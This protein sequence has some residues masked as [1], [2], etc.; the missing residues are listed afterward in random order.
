MLRGG[1]RRGV[2][3]KRRGG[4]EGKKEKRAEKSGGGERRWAENRQEGNERDG[5]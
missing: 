5:R 1:D 2:W 3:D 4:L